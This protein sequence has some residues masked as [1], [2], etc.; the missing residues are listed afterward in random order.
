MLHRAESMKEYRAYTI[1]DDDHIVGAIPLVCAN[2]DEAIARVKAL[3]AERAIE[4]WSGD[5]FVT[6]LDPER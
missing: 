3:L 1:G 6:R 2:D 4:I 5:R